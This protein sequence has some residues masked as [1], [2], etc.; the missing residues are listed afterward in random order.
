MGEPNIR[1]GDDTSLELDYFP[2]PPK[3][4]HFEE[5]EGG[6]LGLVYSNTVVVTLWFLDQQ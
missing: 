5:D 1:V 3:Q 2:C 4:Y 6:G